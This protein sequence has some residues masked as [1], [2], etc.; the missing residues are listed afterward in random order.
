MYLGSLG[1]NTIP[2]AVWKCFKVEQRESEEEGGA[3]E[4]GESKV[5]TPV[6]AP[7]S[8]W[9]PH[10]KQKTE[11]ILKILSLDGRRC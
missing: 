8:F 7:G 5:K 1:V 2:G 4:A 6:A 10:Q 9:Q 3:G 11:Q